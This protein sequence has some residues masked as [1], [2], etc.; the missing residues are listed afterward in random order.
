MFCSFCK[1][2]A[3]TSK[4][5][6]AQNSFVTGCQSLKLES[7]KLHQ[8]SLNHQKST[9]IIE[10][11]T[12]V[13]ATPAFK[14][15]CSLNKDILEKLEKMFRNCHA[16]AMN[17]RPFSD[18][19]W[20]CDLDDMKGLSLGKTYRNEKAA[21][22]FTHAIAQVERSKCLSLA[23]NCKFLSILADGTT[24]SSISEQE[25]F[26]IRTSV[27]GEVKVLFTAVVAAEKA[28]APGILSAMEKAIV[29]YLGL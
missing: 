23:Q 20:L 8:V 10:G 27:N 22:V 29:T 13:T 16:I 6:G 14:I 4:D 5:V 25:M 26:C 15:I 2:A 11:R 28:N 24:D 19:V 18:Y 7:I 9:K 17:N 1:E 3:K 12:S 21:I